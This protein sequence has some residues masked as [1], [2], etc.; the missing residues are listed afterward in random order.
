MHEANKQWWDREPGDAKLPEELWSRVC[1]FEGWTEPRLA[2]M[3]GLAWQYERERQLS[4]HIGIGLAAAE[5]AYPS[6]IQ[7]RF[8]W[9]AE[10]PPSLNIIKGSVDTLLARLFTE[11]P[12]LEVHTAGAPFEQRD[13]ARQRSMALDST[14]NS[15]PLLRVQ[16]KIARDGLLKGWGAA[17]PYVSQ[18]QVRIRRLHRYQIAVDPY[19]ARD[20]EPQVIHVWYVVP[21]ATLV[22]STS[23]ARDMRDQA[24][25]LK[26]IKA[27][28]RL[29]TM[30]GPGLHGYYSPYDWDLGSASLGA[31]DDALLVI[32]HIKLP[33]GTG[34]D[35]PMEARGRHVITVHGG[36]GTLDH[37]PVR[38][39]PAHIT[40]W[41]DEWKR[42]TFPCVWWSPYPADEG[43]D[44][45]GI[46]HMLLPWQACVDRAVCKIQ[47][48]L[49]TLSYAKVLMARN[50]GVDVK[51]ALAKGLAIVEV[52]RAVL[53][54][55]AG[56][57]IVNPN[58]LNPEE[59]R[60]LEWVLSASR[61]EI[62]INAM[63]ATGGSRLGA[64]AAAVAMVEEDYRQLDRLADIDAEFADFRIALGRETLHAIDDAVAHDKRF[65]AQWRE[66]DGRLR[67]EP[68]AKL[69]EQ[70]QQYVVDLE[71]VGVLG[72]SKSGRIQRL[73]E[74]TGRIPDLPPE[75]AKE[76]LLTSPDM[77]AIAGDSLAGYRLI[78]R[79]LE[80]LCSDSADHSEAS[81]AD[82][83]VPAEMAVDMAMRKIQRALVEGAE[84]ETLLRLMAYKAQAEERAVKEQP[85]APVMPEMPAPAGP[86]LGPGPLPPEMMN[87][88]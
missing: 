5:A 69:I 9:L 78:Q 16:R 47:K 57:A 6:V 83:H 46:G 15:R 35:L 25:V 85:P 61:N 21:R 62:G 68:W 41:D 40:M 22:A 66:R 14:L 48:T 74:Y 20:G 23:A 84:P 26:A 49:D 37:D 53:G 55:G 43:I 72:R 19:D 13:A 4:L 64:G 33:G 11:L 59:L 71:Q 17:W 70:N 63:L 76:A 32:Q 67:K 50:N 77:E 88:A 45:T 27:M 31:M 80:I 1:A 60:W 58:V 29:D 65:E 36:G 79:H 38:G 51:D 86:G 82:P 12:A 39:A 75:L 28:P 44:G 73:I 81:G 18:G 42:A 54:E 7:K 87:A 56:Y 10:V 30:R 8:H 2:D 34:E 3:A 52:E 24:K